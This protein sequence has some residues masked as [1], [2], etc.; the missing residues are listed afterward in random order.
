MRCKSEED[1]LVMMPKE[2]MEIGMQMKM[3]IQK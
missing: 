1:A 3:E 2:E